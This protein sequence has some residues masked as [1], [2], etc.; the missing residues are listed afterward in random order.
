MGSAHAGRPRQYRPP[1]LT[2]LRIA[3]VAVAFALL[4]VWAPAQAPPRVVV[5]EPVTQDRFDA[6]YARV[7]SLGYDDGRNVRLE[8][9]NARG[10]LDR[11]PAIVAD[12]VATKPD[13]IVALTTPVALAVKR[14]TG[15]IPVVAFSG[16]PVAV[17]L[18]ESVA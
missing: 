6:F 16:D 17:G 3:L 12:V 4:P 7:K 18:V 15:T 10:Q 9:H 8:R 14:A 2:S 11:V 13:V 1:R 5:I